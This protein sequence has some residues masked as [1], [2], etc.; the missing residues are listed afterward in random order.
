MTL[1][2]VEAREA[3]ADALSE[4]DGLT[5]HPVRGGKAPKPGS[6]WVTIGRLVPSDYTRC[7]VT[8]VAVVVLGSDQASAED[9]LNTWAVDVIDA[10]TTVDELP[11]ADVALEPILL[12]AGTDAVPVNA[13][14][15]TITT[16][17]ES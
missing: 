9:L 10:V 15:I 4:I 12:T 6:G 17:V 2:L 13:F 11:T 1:T 7:S 5:V 16:E 8:L 3:L 14:T